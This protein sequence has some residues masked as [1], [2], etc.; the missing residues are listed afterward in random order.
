M[1]GVCFPAGDEGYSFLHGGDGAAYFRKRVTD[2][3][4]ALIRAN[5]AVL[6]HTAAA[7]RPP[8]PQHGAAQQGGPPRLTVEQ[9]ARVLQE[10]QLPGGQAP[11]AHRQAAGEGSAE[12]AATGGAPES[13]AA[14]REALL[15]RAESAGL[16]RKGGALSS[17]FVKAGALAPEAGG[18]TSAEAEAVR[19]ACCVLC[20]AHA[21]AA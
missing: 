13:G 11:A 5:A 9:R 15:A 16:L 17:R 19:C 2:I 6:H 3:H 12:A 1:H 4:T 21:N 14:R 20:A 18:W 10:P 7:L 8:Q